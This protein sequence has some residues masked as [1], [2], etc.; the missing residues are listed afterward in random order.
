MQKLVRRTPR[1]GRT[2]WA[3]DCVLQRRAPSGN[4]T[5]TARWSRTA[6]PTKPRVI[7]IRGRFLTDISW[8]ARAVTTP[9]GACR[10]PA[11]T[12]HMW[13]CNRTPG[14]QY[15]AHRVSQQRV[16]NRPACAL[17]SHETRFTGHAHPSIV[18]QITS[19]PGRRSLGNLPAPPTLSPPCP[20]TRSAAAMP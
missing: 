15:R 1:P 18:G 2:P 8:R 14:F 11:R 4:A 3:L 12:A 13:R 20:P 5:A 9:K 17:P 6:T 19:D 16:Q 10:A 7:P